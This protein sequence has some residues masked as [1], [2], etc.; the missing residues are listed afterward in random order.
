MYFR[1]ENANYRRLADVIL[2]RGI[3]NDHE[4]DWIGCGDRE[5]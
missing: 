1:G 5:D 4:L 2:T 3:L